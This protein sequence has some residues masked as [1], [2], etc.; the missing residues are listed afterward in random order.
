M[1]VLCKPWCLIARNSSL[2]KASEVGFS[3]NIQTRD[4]NQT[5]QSNHEAMQI[6]PYLPWLEMS[7]AKFWDRPTTLLTSKIMAWKL[8]HFLELISLPRWQQWCQ[9][10][11][12]NR[13]S[14]FVIVSIGL[15]KSGWETEQWKRNFSNCKCNQ[16]AHAYP[17]ESC[18]LIKEISANH[19]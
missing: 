16:N 14:S 5:Q 3:L 6:S 17:S 11:E 1:V 10:M 18:Y 13:C 9:C 7:P 12:N 8:D 4:Q 2:F 19:S 15:S